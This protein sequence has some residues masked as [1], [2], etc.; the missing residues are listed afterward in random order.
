MSKILNNT[1]RCKK[2]GDVITS[3][4]V[5][6]FITCTCGAVSADGGKEYLRRCFPGQPASDHYE[7]LS[8]HAI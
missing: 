3:T 5:H 4:H 2:C 6:H 7:E 8:T 1:I